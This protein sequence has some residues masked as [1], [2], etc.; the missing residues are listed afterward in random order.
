VVVTRKPILQIVLLTV[1]L[2]VYGNEALAQYT[3]GQSNRSTRMAGPEP[4]NVVSLH[5][6]QYDFTQQKIVY[7]TCTVSIHNTSGTPSDATSVI[8]LNDNFGSPSNPVCSQQQHATIPDNSWGQIVTSGQWALVVGT[9][10]RY[11]CDVS[12][13]E[14]VADE[15]NDLICS[16]NYQF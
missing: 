7:C 5:F 8:C 4:T 9:N 3:V 2:L 15:V 14:P 16:A 12:S 6:G 1:C 13:S 11:Y 10:V